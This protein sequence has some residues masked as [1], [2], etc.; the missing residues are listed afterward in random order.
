MRASHRGEWD[1]ERE[2]ETAYAIGCVCVYACMLAYSGSQHVS[3]PAVLYVVT[4]WHQS[5]KPLKSCWTDV[6]LLSQFPRWY[7][8]YRPGTL[9]SFSSL[10]VFSSVF[11]IYSSIKLLS[12]SVLSTVNTL[13]NLSS[14]PFPF[15]SLLFAIQTVFFPGLCWT[16]HFQILCSAK[17]PGEMDSWWSAH[18]V[19]V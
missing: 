13:F 5:K 16:S 4:A 19:L 10:C 17:R 8:T 2:R 7:N 9:T 3:T 12:F 1:S 15:I 6:S 18:G 14:P 11:P